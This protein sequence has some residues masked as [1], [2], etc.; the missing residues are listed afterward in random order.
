V[1]PK[2]FERGGKLFGFGL[3]SDASFEGQFEEVEGTFSPNREIGEPIFI[4]CISA[5]GAQRPLTVFNNGG[6]LADAGLDEYPEDQSN[7][8]ANFP[9]EGIINLPHFDN[10][11]Y[12]GPGVEDAEADEDVD[13]KTAVRDPANWEGS[14]DIRYGLDSGAANRSL[15]WTTLLLGVVGVMTSLL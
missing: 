8:P 15:V 10:L 5:S 13:L 1:A 7:L 9:E 3:D 11:L 12:K 14:N 4:Y 6:S 2:G